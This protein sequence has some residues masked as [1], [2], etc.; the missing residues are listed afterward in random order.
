MLGVGPKAALAPVNSKRPPG[1][2]ILQERCAAM[3]EDCTFIW[4]IWWTDE[5]T[6]A[7]SIGPPG[8]PPA[9]QSTASTWSVPSASVIFS[10]SDSMLLPSMRIDCVAF[11]LTRKSTE[12]TF[13]P[14]VLNLWRTTSPSW[15][16][17]PYI[18][19]DFDAIFFLFFFFFFFFY[20]FLFFFFFFH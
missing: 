3:T 12:Y 15:P 9:T 13:Q 20:L 4:Y 14:A 8:P 19:S 17:P 1:R 7:S 2:T 5:N 16:A 6:D 18:N 11:S 10:Q